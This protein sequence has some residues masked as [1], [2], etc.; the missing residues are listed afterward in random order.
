MSL[1]LNSRRYLQE[2][3]EEAWKKNLETPNEF[4]SEAYRQLAYAA[5]RLDALEGR[6]V[7]TAVPET[8]QGE[9]NPLTISELPG[10][11]SGGCCGGDCGCHEPS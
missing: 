7:N 6:T 2:L 3:R 8:I 5:D 10:Y 11:Y 4:W 9:G 1:P